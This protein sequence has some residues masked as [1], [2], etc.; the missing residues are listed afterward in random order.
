MQSLPKNKE[1]KELLNKIGSSFLKARQKAIKAI[2][3][4]LT[5]SNWNTGKYIVEYE[6]KG[7]IKAEYGKE[8]L[9]LLSKDLPLVLVCNEYRIE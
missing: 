8:L 9:D 2:N 5:L 4:E 1:H 6:Q 7:N 3:A